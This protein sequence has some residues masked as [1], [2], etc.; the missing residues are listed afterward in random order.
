MHDALRLGFQ[1]LL[2]ED[3]VRAVDVAPGDGERAIEEM[4]R[5]GA[6][7]TRLESVAA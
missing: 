4:R 7:I 5:L 2:L 3:A 6:K 1:V